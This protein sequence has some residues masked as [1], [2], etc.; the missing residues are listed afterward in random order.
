[1]GL[2]GR[3]V[4]KKD[5]KTLNMEDDDAGGKRPGGLRRIYALQVMPLECLV[6]G[7][8]VLWSRVVVRQ[9]HPVPAYSRGGDERFRVASDRNFEPGRVWVVS[10]GGN[11]PFRGGGRAR[12]DWTWRGGGAEVKIKSVQSMMQSDAID[13][14]A[15]SRRV[16]GRGIISAIWTARRTMRHGAFCLRL[17]PDSR[18]FAPPCLT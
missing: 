13:R 2:V 10:G 4:E 14:V 1:M 6:G 12:T 11:K 8:V 9:I 17:S 16:A 3:A 5:R 15:A 18:D 7:T